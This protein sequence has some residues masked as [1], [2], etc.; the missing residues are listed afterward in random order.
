MLKGVLHYEKSRVK[1]FNLS[2]GQ[3]SIA[4]NKHFRVISTYIKMYNPLLFLLGIYGV[5]KHRNL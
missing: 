5:Y 1:H 4:E 2:K 3:I